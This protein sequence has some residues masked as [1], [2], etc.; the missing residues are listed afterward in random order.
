MPAEFLLLF[1]ERKKRA[2]AD[3]APRKNK[4]GDR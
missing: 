2:V 4:G 1:A 3:T